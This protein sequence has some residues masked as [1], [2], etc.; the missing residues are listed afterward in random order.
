[1]EK[2]SSSEL[3]KI[4]L[5]LQEEKEK[6]LKDNKKVIDLEEKI[7]NGKKDA[8]EF[9]IYTIFSGIAVFSTNM[10]LPFFPFMVITA[11]WMYKTIKQI[12]K[13]SKNIDLYKKAL[14]V[15]ENNKSMIELLIKNI[16]SNIA[17]CHHRHQ[18]ELSLEDVKKVN[19]FLKYDNRYREDIEEINKKYNYN[20]NEEVSYQKKIGV[21]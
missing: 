16:D 11:F 3:M 4:I 9:L 14:L 21:R 20:S 8:K 10:V 18:L 5:E 17:I 1:M 2:I 19:N 12:E 13:N 7:K 6:L 15:Q